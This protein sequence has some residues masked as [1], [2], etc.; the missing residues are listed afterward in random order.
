MKW[1]PESARKLGDAGWKAC[2]TRF[3]RARNGQV[4]RAESTHMW[5][6]LSSLRVFLIRR[7]TQL[8]Y[9]RILGELI[10]LIPYS[11]LGIIM[12]KSRGVPEW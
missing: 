7:T 2:A 3:S 5:R 1:E 4:S 10:R 6:G 8:A 12:V 9:V 11:I